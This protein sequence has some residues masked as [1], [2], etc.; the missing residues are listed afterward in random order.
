MFPIV[1]FFFF[2]FFLDLA[3][4]KLK[5]QISCKSFFYLLDKNSGVTFNKLDQ[6]I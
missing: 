3:L 2:C 1:F 6:I 5:Y 4:N